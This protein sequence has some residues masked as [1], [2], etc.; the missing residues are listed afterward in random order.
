MSG[1]CCPMPRIISRGKQ[2]GEAVR[3][4]DMSQQVGFIGLGTMGQPMAANLLRAGV[5]LMVWNRSTQKCD[6]LVRAGAHVARDPGEVFARCEAVI[7]MLG[8]APAVDQVLARGTG[9]FAT[10][11][12]DRLLI[13]M[14]TIDPNYS[15][16]LERDVVAAGGRYVEAPV[17]G[18]RKPAESGQLVAMLAGQSVDVE[19]AR[20]LVAR[21]CRSAIDCGV[22][23]NGL[24]M[25][26]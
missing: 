6:E 7:L 3:M 22:I 2:H 8:D 20:S 12:N 24:H 5:A 1:I 16:C 9:S 13:N 19:A 4:A 18:S 17:S 23:P 25:K 10:R 11:V 26:L 14:A 15:E 21:M